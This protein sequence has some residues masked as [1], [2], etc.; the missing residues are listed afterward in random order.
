[1]QIPSTTTVFHWVAGI[2]FMASILHTF[3]LPPWEFLSD[4]PRAQKCYKAFVYFVGFVAVSGRSTIF[5]SI[6]INNPDGVN[7]TGVSTTTVVVPVD[8]V[9]TTPVKPPSV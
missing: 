5:K 1:M 7:T 2:G 4:F 9:T 8:V 6:S 3:F